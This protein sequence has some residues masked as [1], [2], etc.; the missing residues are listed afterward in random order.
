MLTYPPT[1]PS[2]HT[3]PVT[4]HMLTRQMEHFLEKQLHILL[5]D[6]HFLLALSGG[7]DSLALLCCFLWL[8][9]MNTAQRI[10]LSVVHMDHALRPESGTEARAAQALCTAWNIPFY[11]QRTDIVRYAKAL[12]HKEGH[13]IE[14]TSRKARYE[15]FEQC[16]RDCNAHWIVLGHHAGDL[17][18]DLLMRLVRGTGWPALGGMVAIDKERRILRPLLLQEPKHLRKALRHAHMTWIE[19]MSNTDRHFLRNR[20]RHDILP[21]LHKENSAF[22]QTISQIWHMAQA[23]KEHWHT[24]LRTM[25]ATHAIVRIQTHYRHEVHIPAEALTYADKATRLRLYI[26]AMK[27][28]IPHTQ[29]RAHTLF[30]LDTALTEGRGGVVFQFSQKI[31]A[32]LKKRAITFTCPLP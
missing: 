3:Q 5:N 14:D 12:G 32:H 9:E 22:P 25:C 30:Q 4:T 23:D 26:H 29:A 15:Y 31:C 21:L 11:M 6:T 28:L 20:I 1:P 10:R 17:Q 8:T 24:L 19:D 27:L 18:E 13:S 7:A 16:R 2:I